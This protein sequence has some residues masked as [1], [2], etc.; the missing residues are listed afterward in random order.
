MLRYEKNFE[1]RNIETI[2]KPNNQDNYR[3]FLIDILDIDLAN[4]IRHFYH[5]SFCI[6]N[7]FHKN[8][9]RFVQAFY[10]PV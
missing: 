9:V 3:A 6:S 10:Q 4:F 1:N 7:H 8:K 2:K 5:G